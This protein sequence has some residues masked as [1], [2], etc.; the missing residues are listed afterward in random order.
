MVFLTYVKR[1]SLDLGC[2]FEFYPRSEYTYT[3]I[4]RSVLK[5]IAQRLIAYAKLAINRQ[6]KKK[7]PVLSP[8]SITDGSKNMLMLLSSFNKM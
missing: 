5:V 7:R 8:P 1:D 4:F 3:L 6:V 2:S